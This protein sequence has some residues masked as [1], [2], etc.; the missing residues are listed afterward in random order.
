[1]LGLP[2]PLSLRSPGLSVFH[3]KHTNWNCYSLCFEIYLA[4]TNIVGRHGHIFIFHVF[5]FQFCIYSLQF[6]SCKECVLE[7]PLSLNSLIKHAFCW[8]WSMML[9]DL[10]KLLLLIAALQHRVVYYSF[11]C[12]VSSCL[13]SSPALFW[14]VVTKI[15]KF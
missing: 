13:F 8:L 4:D 3:L 14:N 9:L 1:M 15:K 10:K 7:N 6:I 11:S 5:T 12:P 2:I